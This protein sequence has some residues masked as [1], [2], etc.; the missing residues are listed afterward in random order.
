MPEGFQDW[1]GQT[2]RNVDL[3]DTSWKETVLVN[4]RFSGLITGLVVNDIEVAPLIDTE[5]NRRFPE[6][7][8][9]RPADA[10]GV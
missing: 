8:K 6:R 5:M 9:L 3:S 4:A 1:S 2:F 7:T 10:A